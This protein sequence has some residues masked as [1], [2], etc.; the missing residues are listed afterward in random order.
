M[1]KSAKLPQLNWK[2]TKCE[3]CGNEFDYFTSKRPRVCKNGDC[4]YKFHYKIDQK[5]WAGYQP[6]L[7]DTKEKN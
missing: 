5:S 4:K 3:V 2:K 6:T 7:F 1:E